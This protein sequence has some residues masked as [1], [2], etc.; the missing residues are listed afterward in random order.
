MV[1]SGLVGPAAHGRKTLVV[2]RPAWYIV[3]M[4]TRVRHL[5]EEVLRH[6]AQDS[7]GPC[8]SIY[9]PP[10]R[11]SIG[12]LATERRVEELR[13]AARDQL[14]APPW[15]LDDATVAALLEP[16][17]QR[18]DNVERE[19]NEGVAIFVTA[20]STDLVIVPGNA[21]A[22]VTVASEPDLLPLVAALAAR[23]EFDLLVLSPDHVQLFRSNARA[24]QP[25][26]RYDLPRNRDDTRWNEPH[27]AQLDAPHPEAGDGD[28]RASA[29][30]RFIE[31]V[32]RRLPA[33]V[34]EGRV[35]LV[36]AA[37]DDDA[38]VFRLVSSHPKLLTLTELGSPA[39][40]S[41]ARLH[42]AAADLVVEHGCEDHEARRTRFADLARTGH[43]AREVCELRAAVADGRIETLFVGDHTA[44]PTATM[45]QIV[46]GTL[47]SGGTVLASAP[48]DEI[49]P[50]VAATLRA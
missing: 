7:A 27:E 17:I 28:E 18:F 12:R 14:V 50:I 42:D 5:D 34:R 46:A 15:S 40:V 41:L 47:R 43:T 3:D 24:L 37:V 23:T 44:L 35:P 48:S 22:L 4:T 10:Q 26:A 11:G 16:A 2:A 32:E 29:T 25:M 39:G 38:A 19:P 6:L 30:W 20:C 21:P 9:L 49:E 1:V 33:A 31:T 36:V 8:V 45:L 13:R